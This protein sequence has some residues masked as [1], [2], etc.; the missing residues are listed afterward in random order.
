MFG[1]MLVAGLLVVV[2]LKSWLVCFLFCR[3]FLGCCSGGGGQKTT[4]GLQILFLGGVETTTSS[5]GGLK[6]TITSAAVFV[7]RM[8]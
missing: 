4:T 3:C 7:S 6:K 8:W 1:E 2:V 5:E